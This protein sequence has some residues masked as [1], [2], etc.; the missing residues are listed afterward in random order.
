M[1]AKFDV[2][3]HLPLLS[4]SF[5]EAGLVRQLDFGVPISDFQDWN[6]RWG[7]MPT[8]HLLRVW[9]SGSGTIAY[10]ASALAVEPSPDLKYLP[11]S[12]QQ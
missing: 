5:T 12:H 6:Y 7:T 4:T 2:R 9:G 1:E 11:G 8:W 10:A 3:N